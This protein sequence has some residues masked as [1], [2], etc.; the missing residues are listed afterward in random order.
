MDATA[1][2]AA[3]G[4]EEGPVLLV[5]VLAPDREIVRDERAAAVEAVAIVTIAVVGETVTMARMKRQRK[6]N[7]VATASRTDKMV[8]KTC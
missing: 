7:N 1:L 5:H 3:A 4:D 8:A 6:P 2:E